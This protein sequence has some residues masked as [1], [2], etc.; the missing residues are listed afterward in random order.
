MRVKKE[1][2]GEVGER[3][4][5]RRKHVAGRRSGSLGQ[6]TV[7]GRC[8]RDHKR[9]S[10]PPRE[11]SQGRKQSSSYQPRM[12]Q[13]PRQGYRQHA[14]AAAAA[15]PAVVAETAPTLCNFKVVCIVAGDR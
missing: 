3:A 4:S 1:R 6:G 11:S 9:P 5:R 2:G 15:A 8:M 12:Q 7:M 10:T 14:V 13:F